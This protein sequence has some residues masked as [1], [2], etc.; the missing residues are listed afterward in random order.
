MGWW[1]LKPEEELSAYQMLM[2][3]SKDD[4][5]ENYI[6]LEDILTYDVEKGYK[7]SEVDREHITEMIKQGYVSGEINDWDW[8]SEKRRKELKH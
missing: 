4:L 2:F 3:G 1:E 8:M 6:D 5:G 7:L